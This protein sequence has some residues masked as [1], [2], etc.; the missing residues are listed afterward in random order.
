MGGGGSKAITTTDVSIR[1]ALDATTKN[2]V[3]CNSTV[4]VSQEIHVT[5]SG[6]IV[7]IKQAQFL[8]LSATCLQD[9]EN[10]ENLQTAITQALQGAA[11]SQSVSVLGALGSSRAEVNNYIKNEIEQKITRET[12]TEAINSAN[13]QQIAIISGDENIV[14]IDQDTAY[15]IMYDTLQNVVNKLDSTVV[16]DS[17]VKSGAEATQTNFISEIVDSI[18][19]I[20]SEGWM[21]IVAIVFIVA[22]IFVFGGFDVIKEFIPS[23]SVIDDAIKT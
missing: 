1:N 8:R 6:N 9:A 4:K 22:M 21:A 15:E 10:V 7:R 13:M 23:T 3:K 2:I 14:D 20:F 19:D 5:G 17:N 16:I 12:L 11:K 18:G